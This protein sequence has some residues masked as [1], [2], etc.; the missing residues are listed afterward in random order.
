MVV[1]TNPILLSPLTDKCIRHFWM[2]SVLWAISGEVESFS[3][4]NLFGLYLADM[5]RSVA[6][7]N[8]YPMGVSAVGI[9]TTLIAV[10]IRRDLESG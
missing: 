7:R 4:N 3:T 9:V 2:F 5:G 10:C 1:A 6:V 8:N